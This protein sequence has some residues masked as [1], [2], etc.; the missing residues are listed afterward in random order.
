VFKKVPYDSVNDITP[1]SVVGSTPFV[2]VVNPKVPAKN[3]K[4]LQALL[5]SKPASYNHASAGN[6]TIVHLANEMF[7]R[8]L[9]V[10]VKHIP[11]KGTG[12]RSPT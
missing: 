4:E 6:G 8:R 5:K 10:D 2:V 11:Y 3:A 9:G 12:R 7:V 1:I